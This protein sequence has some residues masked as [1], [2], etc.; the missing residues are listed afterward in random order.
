MNLIQRIAAAAFAASV[1][2][3]TVW[4]MAQLGY[5]EPGMRAEMVARA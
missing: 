1:T 5:P 3:S 2:F 4:S